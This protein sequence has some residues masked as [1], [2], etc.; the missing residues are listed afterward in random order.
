MSAVLSLIPLNSFGENT[1]NGSET[2]CV[3][4]VSPELKSVKVSIIILF[5]DKLTADKPHKPP[6]LGSLPPKPGVIELCSLMPAERL[7]A[8]RT[9]VMILNHH[10]NPESGFRNRGLWEIGWRIF[11]INRKPLTL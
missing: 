8:I 6:D 5:A 11:M 4:S 7:P 2:V 3:I 1:S 9:V 10:W